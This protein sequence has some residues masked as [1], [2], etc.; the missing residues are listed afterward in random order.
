[1]ASRSEYAQFNF[2]NLG[3][4]LKFRMFG[5]VTVNYIT[6]IPNDSNAKVSGKASVDVNSRELVMS[7][8]ANSSVRLNCSD[9][10]KLTS[11]PTDFLMVVPAQKYTG[12]FTITI[13]TN[14]GTI[15]K[16]IK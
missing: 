5:D 6:F 9:G 13:S 14:E 10:V 12:G 4:I 16:T 8:D 15:V 3:S 2:K 7:D 11:E 1:M